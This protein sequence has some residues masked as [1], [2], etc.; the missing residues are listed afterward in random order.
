MNIS[1][2]NSTGG[3]W[4]DFNR[5]GLLD[6]VAISHNADS[7]G[8]ALM[9]NQDRSRFVKVNERAGDIDDRFPTEG[10]AWIDIDGTGYPSLYCAN[11]EKW[12]VRAGYPDFLWHNDKGYFSDMSE[13]LGFRS[14]A[15]TDNPGLAGRG[16]APADFDNDGTQEILVTNY[17]LTRNFCWDRQETANSSM[18][19]L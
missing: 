12:Q 10:A 1:Q 5:D 18:W 14:P 2:L 9:K 19:R 4:A 15:Y 13:E 8:E 7:L 11:Y 3:L 17:R 6:F 16:V